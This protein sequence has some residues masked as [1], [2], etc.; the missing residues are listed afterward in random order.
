MQKS[1]TK[2]EKQLKKKTN[3]DLVETVIECK[4]NPA[5]REIAS[6]LSG[7]NSGRVNK[8]LGE[9]EKS[10]KDGEVIIIPGKILSGGELN[11]KI[12]I[13]GFSFSEKAI[14]KLKKNKIEY[15]YILNEVKKNKNA[16]GVKILR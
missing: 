9:I 13:V 3:L 6:V 5:W 14:D 16:K 4:K 15:D 11:K 7:P 1:N 2:I 12:K 8:N 10:C